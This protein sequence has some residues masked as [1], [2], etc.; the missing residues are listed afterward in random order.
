MTGFPWSFKFQNSHPKPPV[1]HQLQLRFFYPIWN[2]FPWRFQLVRLH[3]DKP[4]IPI[5]AEFLSNVEGH[6]L[7]CVLISIQILVELLIF[8]S[9][10]LFTVVLGWSQLSIYLHV[11]LETKSHQY[12]QFST[13]AFKYFMILNLQ[14]FF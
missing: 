5:F 1:I 2:W 13:K 10:Q 4:Q 14:F 12:R 8:Q 3:F 7:P 11:E 9:V 6:G